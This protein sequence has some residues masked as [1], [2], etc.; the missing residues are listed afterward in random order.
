M[1][2]AT[3]STILGNTIQHDSS[4]V[5]HAWR[6]IDARDLPADVAEEIA[7]EIEDGECDE[8]DDY[9]ASNEQPTQRTEAMKMQNTTTGEI[10]GA[11]LI[12]TDEEGRKVYQSTDGWELV[13]DDGAPV[14]CECDSDGN[15]V[16][17]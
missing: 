12:G 1:T 13:S 7:A 15:Y 5:G 11:H 17:E 16:V 6:T 2:T 8:C 9:V 3:E 14:A 4:G 10:S